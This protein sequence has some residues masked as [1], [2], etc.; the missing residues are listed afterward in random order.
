MAIKNILMGIYEIKNILNNKIY[1]G[2][3]INLKNRFKRHKCE[4]RTNKHTNG[5]LQ[6]AYNKYGKDNFSFSIIEMVTDESKLLEREQYWINKTKCYNENFGYNIA[7][8]A[9]SPQKGKTLS[10]DHKRKI[11]EKEKGKIVSRETKE[12][13]RQVN[14]GKKMGLETRKKQ[15]I[16]KKGEKNCNYGKSFSKKN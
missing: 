14:L 10:E 11:S 16:A 6:R 12:R 2:S 4:L 1:I 13:L 7:I 3:S 8:Y 9:G 5:H 15:S